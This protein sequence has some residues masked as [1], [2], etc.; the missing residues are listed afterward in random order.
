MRVLASCEEEH[1]V[2]LSAIRVAAGSELACGRR[3]PREL[4]GIEPQTDPVG[5][6]PV[7]S[8]EAP[9]AWV[10][11]YSAHLRQGLSGLEDA[12][13]CLSQGAR[14]LDYLAAAKGTLLARSS[15]LPPRSS[16]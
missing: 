1:Q 9:S 14:A 4:Y 10:P 15:P 5:P 2:L 12:V 11:A 8:P 7:N 3:V 13:V 16:R 6:E